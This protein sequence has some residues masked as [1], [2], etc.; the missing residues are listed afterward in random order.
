[1]IVKVLIV[2]ELDSRL[3]LPSKLALECRNR[4]VVVGGNFGNR[5]ELQLTKGEHENILLPLWKMGIKGGFL[6]YMNS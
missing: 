6:R 2:A 1:M 4:G 5:H 3:S